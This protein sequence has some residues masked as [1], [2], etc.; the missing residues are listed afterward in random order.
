[1][2]KAKKHGYRQLDLGIS[3]VMG[4]LDVNLARYKS[5]LGAVATLKPAY[6]KFPESSS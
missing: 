3:S 5:N 1:M 4:S 6:R 2:E